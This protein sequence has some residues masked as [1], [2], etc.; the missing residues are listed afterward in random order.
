MKKKSIL[1]C[2]FLLISFVTKAQITMP[3]A[4]PAATVST[5][6]GLSEI[7]VQYSRPKAKGRKIF[8]KG[9]EYVVQHGELWRTAANAG[10]VITFLEDLKFGGKDVPKG[11][12]LI[13][14]IPGESDWT[15]ILY[16]DIAMG[17]DTDAYKQENDQVRVIV[18]AQKMAEKVETF[19]IEIADLSETGNMAHLQ[20]MWENTSIKVPIQVDF[21]ARVMKSIEANTKVNPNNLVLAANFYLDNGKDLK[22]AL[23][24]INTALESNPTAF[25]M[26]HY[27]AKIQNAMGDK[28]GAL[29]SSKAS[30]EEAK[31]AGREDFMRSNEEL[32]KRLK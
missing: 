15:V 17:G 5:I 16:K 26:L 31:K 27:K 2:V 25:W 19:T 30:W 13:L 12:Y 14:T 7:K 11:S 23:T 29:A 18:K 6:V 22:Q 28:V 1:F 8:G 20:L 10:S 3:A 4:S 24:W 9:S 21:D 32:Q